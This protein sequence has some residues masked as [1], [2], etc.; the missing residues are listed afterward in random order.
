MVDH[1]TPSPPSQWWFSALLAVHGVPLSRRFNVL[2]LYIGNVYLGWQTMVIISGISERTF[3]LRL[4]C[5]PWRESLSWRF[6]FFYRFG[7][8][9]YQRETEEQTKSTEEAMTTPW[10]KMLPPSAPQSWDVSHECVTHL[11]LLAHIA[12]NTTCV[13]GIDRPRVYNLRCSVHATIMPRKRK[14]AEPCTTVRHF[15]F[16]LLRCILVTMTSCH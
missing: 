4:T 12:L 14:D 2:P 1:I 13:L 16:R 3:Y 15:C 8:Q 9:K 11:V 5:R 6:I 10:V 7:N